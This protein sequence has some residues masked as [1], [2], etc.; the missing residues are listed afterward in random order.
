MIASR[1]YETNPN[2]LCGG[3]SLFQLTERHKHGY[4]ANSKYKNEA[5]DFH[6]AN[7]RDNFINFLKNITPLPTSTEKD[8]ISRSVLAMIDWAQQKFFT[9]GCNAGKSSKREKSFPLKEWWHTYWYTEIQNMVP[10]TLFED[11]KYPVKE[12]GYLTVTLSSVP[13]A[14]K[15]F[16]FTFSQVQ[17][18]ARQPNYCRHDK[19]QSHYLLELPVAAHEE[20]KR[21]NQALVDLSKNILTYILNN[22]SPDSDLIRVNND[23]IIQSGT[24]NLRSI[25][26]NN[27]SSNNNTT[28]GKTLRKDA[29]VKTPTQQSADDETVLSNFSLSINSD[30][31]TALQPDNVAR[32]NLKKDNTEKKRNK[33]APTINTKVIHHSQDLIDTG[34]DNNE[35]TAVDSL[36]SFGESTTFLQEPI[37]LFPSHSQSNTVISSFSSGDSIPD[38]PAKPAFKV[39]KPPTSDNANCASYDLR[40]RTHKQLIAPCSPVQRRGARRTSKKTRL[41]NSAPA[42][43]R[44]DRRRNNFNSAYCRKKGSD[45]LVLNEN[46]D[47]AY[48]SPQKI[49]YNILLEEQARS[50]SPTK[51]RPP[52]NTDDFSKPH[53]LAIHSFDIAQII[54][55]H[56]MYTFKRLY[57]VGTQLGFIYDDITQKIVH[58]CSSSPY[59]NNDAFEL[60][61]KFVMGFILSPVST[62]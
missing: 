62:N 56:P 47:E 52:S 38:F 15:G 39:S 59:S 44:S 54:G 57:S 28:T 22:F 48:Y 10:M 33:Q 4:S 53:W 50:Q 6:N 58:Y 23:T 19:H 42:S 14:V 60:Y 36:L 2:G 18:I 61:L 3:I 1:Y 5:L 25:C 45:D 26:S 20:I 43:A 16:K 32:I 7:T 12:P 35:R 46:N 41:Q 9:A 24:Y 21:M 40:S 13:D 11:T 17:D 8:K 37:V 27:N 34:I 31:S 29:T 55:K 51:K 30:M 49:Q